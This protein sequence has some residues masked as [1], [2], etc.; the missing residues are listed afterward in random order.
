M[1]GISL[2]DD[3]NSPPVLLYADTEKKKTFFHTRTFLSLIPYKKK[4][5]IARRFLSLLLSF[6]TLN[7]P[8][9]RNKKTDKKIGRISVLKF[10]LYTFFLSHMWEYHTCIHVYIFILESK[11]ANTCTFVCGEK[12]EKEEKTHIAFTR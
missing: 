7:F 2:A 8:P 11:L 3:A 10:P 6:T 9:Y 1:P 12:K 4:T 5:K